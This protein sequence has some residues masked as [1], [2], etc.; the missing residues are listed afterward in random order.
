MI[1][2]SPR[3]FNN[4][5]KSPMLRKFT[6]IGTVVNENIYQIEIHSLLKPFRR[7]MEFEKVKSLDVFR[8]LRDLDFIEDKREWWRTFERKEC[9]EI[10]EKDFEVIARAMRARTD[11]LKKEKKMH[12]AFKRAEDEGIVERPGILAEPGG[13]GRRKEPY[14]TT[15]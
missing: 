3:G 12:Q 13:T 10:S 11:R 2:Y 5:S 1:F 6:T 9:F 14:D 15:K 8:V 4:P 7:D